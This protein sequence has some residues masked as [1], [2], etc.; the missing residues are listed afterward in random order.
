[1]RRIDYPRAPVT[2]AAMVIHG[3]GNSIMA[4]ASAS[5]T[6][7]WWMAQMATMDP[8]AGKGITINNRGVGGQSI[9]TERAGY[10]GLMMSVTAP[11]AIDA[12]LVA[13][14]INVLICSEFVNELAAN[15]YNGAAAHASWKTYCLARKAAAA[16]A[17]RT[18]RI[19]T[20]TTQPFGSVS[21]P[22]ATVDSRMAQLII[23]NNLMRQSYREYADVLCDIAAHGA[24]G[25]MYG[26]NVWTQAAFVAAGVYAPSNGS[27]IDYLHPGNSGHTIIARCAARA[28]T[29]VRR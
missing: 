10:E 17:G 21:A 3:H 18:L 20:C 24:F 5:D 23:A 7:M 12:N 27:S 26:A 16:S 28:I 11:S 14:K 15:G 22:Q 25:A 6:S 1:M 4:G 9:A 29:R 13:G 2:S 19:I 8:L